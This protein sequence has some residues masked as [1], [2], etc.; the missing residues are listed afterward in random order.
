LKSLWRKVERPE[1]LQDVG[2]V[3]GQS[4]GLGG[5]EAEGIE[6]VEKKKGLP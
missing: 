1:F 6:T 3:E 4:K 5:A 2:R